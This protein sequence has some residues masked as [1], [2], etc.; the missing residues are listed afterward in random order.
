MGLNGPRREVWVTGLG[1]VSSLAAT[2]DEHWLT[3]NGTPA[4]RLAELR[5]TGCAVHPLPAI[6]YSSEIPNPM[7]RKRMGPL[8][9]LGV[10][11]AGQ[12]LGSAGLKGNEGILSR[13][14]V[15][16]GGAGGERDIALD[17]AIFSEPL[18][19]AAPAALNQKL[20]ERMRP[21]LF[22]SQLPNLLAGNISI[23]HGVGG[24]SRTTM[25]DELAGA[26][27]AK[28][29]FDLVADGNYDVA[30]VGGAFNAERL[31]LLLLY[32]SGDYLWRQPY[33]PVTG[34]DGDGGLL[35][36]TLSAFLVLEDAGHAR[37]RGAIPLA[38]LDG[39]AQR[40]SRRN[41]GDVARAVGELRAQFPSRPGDSPGVI[42]GAT[43]IAGPTNEELGRLAATAARSDLP[44]RLTGSLFGHGMEASFP[45]NL[46]LAA[47]ALRSGRLYP[48]APGDPASPRDGN[49]IDQLFVTGVG[50][51]RGEAAAMLSA[52]GVEA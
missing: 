43:G 36:G 30:L 16:V 37:A 18:T 27:A 39:I 12:A 7:E 19:F 14:A 4:P 48:P 13:A 42:S 51:W 41:P 28:I 2:P 31:D 11:T 22:L 17:E 23:L 24:G 9:A 47:L 21:S 40:H 33:R 29:A 46:A 52:V 32:G 25:G 5:N 38:R 1:L 10:Y 15:I 50:H 35:L 6:D 3:L 8:Q 49:D 34:R 45:F 20:S 26:T 44:I